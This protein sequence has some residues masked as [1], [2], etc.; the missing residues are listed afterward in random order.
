MSERNREVGG[1][2]ATEKRNKK[3]GDAADE[4]ASTW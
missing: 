4:D 1:R 2:H 3:E